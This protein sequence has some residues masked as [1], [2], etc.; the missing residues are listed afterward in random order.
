[1]PIY[2]KFANV[3]IPEVSF[4]EYIFAALK[5]GGD[6]IAIV[7]ITDKRDQMRGYLFRTVSNYLGPTLGTFAL[8]LVTSCRPVCLDG[9]PQPT[10]VP[11]SQEIF[12]HI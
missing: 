3:A 10:F 7:S 1:M 4:S 8:M 12:Q 11:C 6:R 9:L 5:R 2:S